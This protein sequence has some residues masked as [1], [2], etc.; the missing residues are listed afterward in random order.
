MPGHP[1]AIRSGNY[2]SESTNRGVLPRFAHRRASCRDAGRA[3]DYGQRQQY[4]ASPGNWHFG[5]NSTS[6]HGILRS[7]SVDTDLCPTTAQYRS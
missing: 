4:A 2:R 7:S 3:C 5:A 6:V 1:V